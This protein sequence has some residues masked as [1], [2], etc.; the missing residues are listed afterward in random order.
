MRKS[1]EH[2]VAGLV[3]Q[4]RQAAKSALSPCPRNHGHATK[5]ATCKLNHPTPEENL[6]EETV[7]CPAQFFSSEPGCV[8][9]LHFPGS[10][11]AHKAK[12]LY[13]SQRNEEMCAM[14]MLGFV[15]K[16]YVSFITSFPSDTWTLNPGS[17]LSTTILI[18]PKRW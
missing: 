13:P 15:R 2:L 4:L 1:A 7:R 5:S 6:C 3:S 14:S 9:G 11:A 12:W 17:R 18:S 10:L 8:S 16:M